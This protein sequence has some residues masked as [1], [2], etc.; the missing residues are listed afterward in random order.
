MC[1]CS[2]KD[3]KEETGNQGPKGEVFSKVRKEGD[4]H[5]E[6]AKEGEGSFY[7]RHVGLICRGP[8]SG[9]LFCWWRREWRAWQLG[10]DASLV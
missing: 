3:I 1:V 6:G 9:A 2:V 10:E 7:K 4:D 8:R 5:P